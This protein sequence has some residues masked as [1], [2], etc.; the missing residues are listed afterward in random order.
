LTVGDDTPFIPGTNATGSGAAVVTNKWQNPANNN[1]PATGQNMHNM[2]FNLDLHPDA[3]E[4]TYFLD[5]TLDAYND[6][7]LATQTIDTTLEVKIYPKVAKLRITDVSVSTGKISPG[8]KFTLDV[9]IQNDG[10]EAAREIYIEFKEAYVSGEAIIET[11]ENINP[12]G[13]KYPFSS[14]VMRSYIAEILPQSTGVATFTVRGDLNIYPGVTYF[15]NIEFN[16][17]DSTGNDHTTIDIAPI[18][19]SS[20]VKASVGGEKYVWDTDREAWISESELASEAVMDWMP[21]MITAAIIVWLVTLL[22]IF[23]FII[24]PRY[25]KEKKQMEVEAAE[26]SE[27]ELPRGRDD[28]VEGAMKSAQKRG[29][30]DEDLDSFEEDDGQTI[31]YRNGNEHQNLDQSSPPLAAPGSVNAPKAL[32]PAP[33]PVAAAP[34]KSKSGTPI[35]T[36]VGDNKEVNENDKDDSDLDFEDTLS[37]DSETVT[38]ENEEKSELPKKGPKNSN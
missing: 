26:D 34:S 17:K 25:K 31:D 9:T 23:L 36:S 12:T 27:S 32:P 20:S 1:L 10:G 21:W 35:A 18:K 37:N 15:Q 13:A 16:Y 5:L 8:K 14:D 29:P 2:Y 3:Q 24:K 19:S 4:G 22:I 7:T 28:S 38:E 30:Q 11:Y 33:K 6:L